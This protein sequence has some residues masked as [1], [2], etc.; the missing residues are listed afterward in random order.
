MFGFESVDATDEWNVSSVVQVGG[1][2]WVL[3]QA[4]YKYRPFL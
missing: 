3:P 4:I 1:G 2:G